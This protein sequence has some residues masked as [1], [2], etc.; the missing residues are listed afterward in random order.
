MTGP[1]GAKGDFIPFFGKCEYEV[2]TSYSFIYMFAGVITYLFCFCLG[3]W[4]ADKIMSGINSFCPHVLFSRSA[5]H[6]G[7]NLLC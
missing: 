5:V 1:K 2:T 7:A 6:I 4:V 3:S